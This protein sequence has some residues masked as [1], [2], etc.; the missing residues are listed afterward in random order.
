MY[1][2]LSTHFRFTYVLVMCCLRSICL[3]FDHYVLP[4]EKKRVLICTNGIAARPD[5][6]FALKGGLL[7]TRGRLNSFHL[8]QKGV[9]LE[10]SWRLN[11][12]LAVSGI[13]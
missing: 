7:V 11:Q 5:W 4:L 9:E 12:G 1:Y 13:E 2:L 8:E 3:L 10:M 6:E